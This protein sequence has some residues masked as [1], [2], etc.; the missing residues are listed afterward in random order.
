MTFQEA[1]HDHVLLMLVK[2]VNAA[3]DPVDEGV[4]VILTVQGQMIAGEVIPNW[5]W[6][7]SITA[8]YRD[9]TIKAGRDIVDDADLGYGYI[10]KMLADEFRSHRD[11]IMNLQQMAED[12]PNLYG[13]ALALVDKTSFIHL[14]SACILAPGQDPLPANRMYW[15][16]RLSE[17]NGWTLGTVQVQ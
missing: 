3:T 13:Q 7:E 1:D 15:R 14:K 2:T 11:E 5:Q 9:A 8:T 10:F 4:G 12:R 17:V 6:A 16:G